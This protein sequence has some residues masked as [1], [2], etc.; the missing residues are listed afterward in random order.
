[1]LFASLL[2]QRWANGKKIGSQTLLLPDPEWL[3]TD[4]IWRIELLQKN[5]LFAQGQRGW[6]QLRQGKCMLAQ[7]KKC[8][9][10]P[11]ILSGEKGAF[12]TGLYGWCQPLCYIIISN[13]CLFCHTLVPQTTNRSLGWNASGLDICPRCL[14]ISSIQLEGFLKLKLNFL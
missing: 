7:R 1:M 3:M 8:P 11:V 9:V 5:G 13:H 4:G 10:N 12:T 2:E 6:I 14:P